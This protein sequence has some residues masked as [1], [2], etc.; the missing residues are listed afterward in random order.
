MVVPNLIKWK[1]INKE[2]EKKNASINQ[3]VRWKVLTFNDAFS[4]IRS[5]GNLQLKKD[6][7]LMKL[8]KE[9]HIF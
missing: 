8:Y 1:A 5:L 2:R 6:V 7:T 4:T 3:V 9:L